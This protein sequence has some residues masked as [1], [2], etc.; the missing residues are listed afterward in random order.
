MWARSVARSR[1]LWLHPKTH[2][3]GIV[4][5]YSTSVSFHSTNPVSASGSI[6]ARWLSDVKQR[7]GKCITFGLTS[8]LLDEA[9]SILQ[10]LSSDWKEL[11]VGNEGYLTGPGR[12]GLDR[13][14]VVWGEMVYCIALT[15]PLLC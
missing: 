1:L 5:R 8:T 15:H 14:A 11:V 6:D 4:Y 13:Q 2:V 3:A 7:I 12:V 9:G 10:K